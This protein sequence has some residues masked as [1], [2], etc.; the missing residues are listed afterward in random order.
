MYVSD[1][2]YADIN[3]KTLLRES[4]E[5]QVII[6]GTFGDG[7]AHKRQVESPESDINYPAKNNGL[8]TSNEYWFDSLIT[9]QWASKHSRSFFKSYL[10]LSEERC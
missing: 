8:K 7:I 6:F 5:T 1:R 2:L 9:V 3:I 4:G 10:L